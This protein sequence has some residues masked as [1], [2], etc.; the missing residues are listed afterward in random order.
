VSVSVDERPTTATDAEGAPLDGEHREVIVVGGGQAGL[1]TSWWLRERGVEHVVLEQHGIG[2]AWRNARWDTFCLVT[3]NWQCRLPGFP[4]SGDDPLGFMVRN[5]IVAYLEAYAGSF[6]PPLV[7]GVTVSA[8]LPATA[9]DPE[10]AR[11]RLETS[12]G[13]L[14]AGQVVVAT[15][16]YHRPTIPRAAERLPADVTQVHSS[17]YRN[18]EQLPTGAV[19]VVGSGQSGAQIAEDLHLAGRRVHLAT[20]SAPRVARFY[21]GRDCTAWLEDMGHYDLPV[22]RHPLG[23]GVRRN[24]NH[25]VTGR[26]GGHDIDLRAFAR[27][28]MRLYGR[29]L[30]VASTPDG[31]VVRL[32]DDLRTNLD[33][34]DE[35]SESIKDGIDRWIDEHGIDAPMEARYE[36]LWEPADGPGE[37]DL[38]AEGIR[39]VVWAI[40]FSSSWPWVRLPVFEGSGYPTHE[41]GVTSVPG[42]YVVG[43]PWLHTWGS[44]R[45]ATVGPDAEHVVD[46]VLALAAPAEE[47]LRGCAAAPDLQESGRVERPRCR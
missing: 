15:G 22:D 20:G 30:D 11:Y 31:A 44:G 10:G 29:L 1:A 16:P 41:R 24:K 40:G 6:D 43:L 17:E 46:R 9:E 39:T 42:C 2:H 25:Y 33:R 21:R 47:A 19:L 8:L 38:A 4:Y 18:P 23:E 12:A 27:D 5:E 34:A 13:T 3:P 36:P 45:F 32:G 26:G 7:T 28:G 37:I 14:T 35:V